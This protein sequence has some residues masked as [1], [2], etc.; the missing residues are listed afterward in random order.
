MHQTSIVHGVRLNPCS[1]GI[2]IECSSGRIVSRRILGLNPCSNGITI[3][4]DER[5]SN[6]ARVEVLILVLME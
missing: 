3:E 5:G 4:C 1:N 2:T 6:A